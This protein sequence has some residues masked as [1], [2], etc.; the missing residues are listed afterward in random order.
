MWDAT[1]GEF[2]FTMAGHADPIPDI[3]FSPDGTKVATARQDATGRIWDATTGVELL[4]LSG[5]SAEIQSIAFSP[6]GKWLATGSGDNTARVWDAATGVLIHTL[7]GS[8]GGVT[9]VAFSPVTEDALLAV[10]SP[11][12]VVRVFLLRMEDLLDLARSR[13]TRPL[14]EPE[15]QLFL[16]MEQCPASDP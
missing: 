8:L 15:C 12:G 7:P 13:V 6:D 2:L 4:T 10:A 5:H 9:G 1:T 14:R 11:D 3:A 16:H